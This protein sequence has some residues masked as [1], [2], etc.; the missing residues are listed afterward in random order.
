[1]PAVATPSWPIHM[2][3]LLTLTS[4]VFLYSS[5]MTVFCAMEPLHHQECNSN[6]CRRRHV[7]IKQTFQQAGKL[8]HQTNK[9]AP[10]PEG[11]PRCSR[12]ACL[13]RHELPHGVQLQRGGR[14]FEDYRVASCTATCAEACIVPNT[15]RDPLGAAPASVVQP[16]SFL[17]RCPGRG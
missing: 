3:S 8:Q 12:L 16:A 4:A 17:R 9:G 14:Q 13:L 2:R 6:Q 15:R 5:P 11:T 7:D 10:I 1:M